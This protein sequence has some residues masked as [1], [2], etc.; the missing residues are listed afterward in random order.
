[1]RLIVIIREDILEA[2]NL[3]NQLIGSKSEKPQTLADSSK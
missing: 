3:E 1:M 2:I